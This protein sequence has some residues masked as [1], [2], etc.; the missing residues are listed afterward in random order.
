[1]PVSIGAIE[2]LLGLGFNSTTEVGVEMLAIVR[3]IFVLGSSSL[4]V[5]FGFGVFTFGRVKLWRP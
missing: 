5:K 1:M 2:V 4:F 3:S